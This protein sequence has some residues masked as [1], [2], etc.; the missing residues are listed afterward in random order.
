MSVKQQEY[1]RVYVVNYLDQLKKSLK[2]KEVYTSYL[3][4][5]QIFKC[6]LPFEGLTSQYRQFVMERAGSKNKI[7]S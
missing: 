4:N 6:I 3:D 1:L 5:Q 2:V 7:N